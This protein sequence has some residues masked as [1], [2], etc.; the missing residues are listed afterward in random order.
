MSSEDRSEKQFQATTGGEGK[1]PSLIFSSRKG[2]EVRVNETED[3]AAFQRMLELEPI[4]DESY[5]QLVLDRLTKSHL[6]ETRQN[7]DQG[8]SN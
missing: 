7:M 3:A 4:C 5:N 1:T 2:S 6:R 8:Q